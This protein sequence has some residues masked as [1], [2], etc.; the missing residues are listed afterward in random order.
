M[1]VYAAMVARACPGLWPT[2]EQ[3][4]DWGANQGVRV[5]LNHQYWRLITSVFLH[6]GM[7]H[8]AMNMWN[9]LV[10]G[11]LVER[12]YGNLAYAVI[13]LA[14]GI[15]RLDRQFGGKSSSNR[16]RG[17]GCD[18]RNPRGAGRLSDR[19]PRADT[20]S[21][22]SNLF[23]A[24]C[25]V[26]SS[27]WP[28]L[29]WFVPNIDQEAHLGGLVTGFRERALTLATLAGCQKPMGTLVALR[30]ADL[31]RRR[32]VRRRPGRHASGC[33]AVAAA[34]SL[35]QESIDQIGP[36]LK[37]YDEIS[38]SGPSTMILKRDRDDPAARARTSRRPFGL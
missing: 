27:S 33:R 16:R 10:V 26:L 18:L 29:G 3:L 13:Y 4:I 9:L 21:R 14:S 24:I 23:A 2:G 25:S 31:D 12:L 35:G 8:L 15:G 19:S 30:R 1:L 20:A 5:V 17:F 32:L 38:D 6:G 22:Y 11:P 36:A 37:D 7:I 28:I 34:D